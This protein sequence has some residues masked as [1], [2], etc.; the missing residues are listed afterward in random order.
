MVQVEQKF[1]NLYL[2]RFIAALLVLLTHAHHYLFEVPDSPTVK[3]LLDFLPAI[4]MP[5]FF[6]LSGFLIHYFYRHLSQYNFGS[7]K[8]YFVARFARLYP[9]YFLV[10]LISLKEYFLSWS[11][12]LWEDIKIIFLH[13]TLLQSWFYSVN[14][15]ELMVPILVVSVSWSLS[16]EFFLYLIYPLFSR[17]F[18]K[19]NLRTAIIGFLL[20]IFFSH[21]VLFSFYSWL[22]YGVPVDVHPSVLPGDFIQWIICFS[23]YVRLLDFISGCFIASIYLSMPK[24]ISKKERVFS[25]I[26]MV[27][28]VCLSIYIYNAMSID[29]GRK[30]YSYFWFIHF[31]FGMTPF[32]AFLIFYCVRYIDFKKNG[33]FSRIIILLGE[34]SYSI[35]LVHML[36]VN[37]L[38]KS[39]HFVTYDLSNVL[40][41]FFVILTIILL[42]IF[43]FKFYEA[44]C[45]FWIRSRMERIQMQQVNV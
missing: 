22:M 1:N 15:N 31:N 12:S 5:L 43:I 18:V 20:S 36:I 23:P 38:K 21:F 2:L 4:G 17:F 37:N 33:F 3:R 35:Y 44:P 34:A 9:L 11:G 8:K 28:C 14:V 45:R 39:I 30:I 41:L 26:L 25:N 10:L 40:F 29:A 42:S 13:L 6:V 27:V 32:M 19:L 7:L 24:D 16:V